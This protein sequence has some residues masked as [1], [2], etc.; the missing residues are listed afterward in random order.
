MDVALLSCSGFAFCLLFLPSLSSLFM[1]PTCRSLH[2]WGGHHVS[3][4]STFYMFRNCSAW[5]W[6]SQKPQPWVVRNLTPLH[7]TFSASNAESGSTSVMLEAAQSSAHQVPACVGHCWESTSTTS[8]PRSR[9]YQLHHRIFYL[10]DPQ[11]HLFF[12]KKTW[13][14]YRRQPYACT[15]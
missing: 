14:K 9:R 5:C 13:I 12:N 15:S 2:I 6:S 11:N 8:T 1:A 7:L 3:P 10:T 4:L